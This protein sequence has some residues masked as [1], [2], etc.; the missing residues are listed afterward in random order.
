MHYNLAPLKNMFSHPYTSN[1]II[2]IEDILN[3]SKFVDEYYTVGEILAS[4]I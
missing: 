2:K 1:L 3:P 4:K